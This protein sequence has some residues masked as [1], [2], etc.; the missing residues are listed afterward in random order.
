[1][2]SLVVF[3]HDPFDSR[4][5]P[6]NAVA[7]SSKFASLVSSASNDFCG[8]DDFPALPNTPAPQWIRF[9]SPPSENDAQ[10]PGPLFVPS[11][12]P[13]PPLESP[14]SDTPDT[15]PPS[16]TPIQGS[17]GKYNSPSSA[18]FLPPSLRMTL[19]FRDRLPHPCPPGR[20]TCK[21][22]APL[23]LD[24][25][26][27]CS[28]LHF[29]SSAGRCPSGCAPPVPPRPP[30]RP[31]PLTPS[32]HPPLRPRPPSPGSTPRSLPPGPSVSN[33]TP[34]LNLPFV[35][36]LLAPLGTYPSPAPLRPSPLPSPLITLPLPSLRPCP[37][38]RSHPAFS[39][40]RPVR[41]Q[42]QVSPQLALRPH[43]L[44][45]P[46]TCPLPTCPAHRQGLSSLPPQLAGPARRLPLTDSP[47]HASV[48]TLITLIS[49]RA[50]SSTPLTLPT[51]HLPAVRP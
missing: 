23:P 35:S 16:V 34:P 6:V 8:H 28:P 27:R 11:P 42:P 17:T 12:D 46:W 45:L 15:P 13:L 14:I 32:P 24:V 30:P 44:A 47:R 1:M 31:C 25:P 36:N 4:A 51:R 29:T 18:T 9:L 49:P 41:L 5:L 37:L 43:N 10:D 21:K 38:P 2:F 50:L 26:P 22:R 33:P 39:H 40:P 20:P 3:L 7:S 19:Y 48:I